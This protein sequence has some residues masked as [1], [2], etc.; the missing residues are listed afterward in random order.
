MHDRYINEVFGK[1]GLLSQC[2]PNYE[3]RQGQVDLANAFDKAIKEQHHILAEGP[4]GV[5]KSFGYLVPAIYHVALGLSG[6]YKRAVVVTANIALQEQLVK[7]DLPTL[8]EILPWNFSFGL[9]KGRNNYLCLR[10][11]NKLVSSNLHKADLDLQRVVEWERETRTGDKSEITFHTRWWPEV[12]SSHEHCLG[13]SCASHETCWASLASTRAK[14]CDIVVLN[15]HVRMIADGLATPLHDI[16]ICD[17][18]HDIPDIARNVLGWTI[19]QYTFRYIS[20]WL[21][22][23]DAKLAEALDNEAQLLFELVKKILDSNLDS[24][25]NNSKKYVKPIKRITQE[26]WFDAKALMSLLSQTI[27]K[28]APVVEE[29]QE[30]KIKS[31]RRK[32]KKA[33][34]AFKAAKQCI[35]RLQ[36]A[37][38][39]DPS[40]VFWLEDKGKGRRAIEARPIEV[41]GILP[42][43]LF[44]KANSVGVISATM[45][46]GHSFDFIRHEIGVPNS[47]DTIIASSPFNLKQQGIIAIPKGIPE[48][49]SGPKADRVPFQEGLV[50]CAETLI[51]LCGGRTLLLFTS[52]VNLNYVHESLLDMNLGVRIL[53]Q[54]DM[55]SKVELLEEFKN[56]E[57]SVLLGVASF[58]QGIDVP[59]NALVGLMID[60]IPFQVPDHPVEQARQELLKGARRSYFFEVSVPRAA[61]LLRQGLGRLIRTTKDVGVIILADRRIETKRFSYG[62]TIARSLPDFSWSPGPRALR[63]FLQSHSVQPLSQE[64]F[65]G[66]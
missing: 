56:D 28:A 37:L 62:G 35:D 51:K 52:W 10:A 63:S 24:N 13:N 19:T 50:K 49:P 47:A 27:L 32:A 14:R 54:G 8:K 33:A 4:T 55:E 31:E 17:E 65:S 25:K 58:W 7:K 22:K 43:L 21:K 20:G 11:F 61:I 30:S 60:K 5:G 44:D 46:V 29:F 48:P 39:L 57:H 36:H 6:R 38:E 40:W 45:T 1:G 64:G 41:N 34:N 15:Y 18:G 16:M 2:L 26:V 23:H 66:P 59:G 9:L 12:S 53:K 42:M 3:L